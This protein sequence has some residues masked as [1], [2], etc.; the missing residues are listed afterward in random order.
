MGA[1]KG[2]APLKKTATPMQPSSR[3]GPPVPL[4]DH[5]HRVHRTLVAGH[6]GPERETRDR[7]GR[8]RPLNAHGPCGQGVEILTLEH[9]MNI[10]AAI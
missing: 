2:P 1:A 9:S 7:E 8:I 5:P 4:G 10:Q 3:S 6:S